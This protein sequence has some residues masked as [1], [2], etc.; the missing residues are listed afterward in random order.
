M[1]Q[2]LYIIDSHAAV[3]RAYHAQARLRQP[4]ASPDGHPT[5]A[6]F[7]FTN[8]LLALLRDHR[9]DLLAVA[10]D[11]PGPTFRHAMYDRYKA[12]RP[13]MPDDLRWQLPKVTA[14]CQGYSIPVFAVSG[15]EADDIIGTL[16]GQAAGAGLEVVIVSDD[17]DVLQLVGGPVRV[18]APSK[19]ERRGRLYDAAEVEKERGLPPA[20]LVDLLALTGDS[21][22]NIPG[23][24]G[25][26]PK[27]AVELLRRYGDLEA[28]LANASKEKGKRRENLEKHAEDARLSYRLATINRA[29]PVQLDPEAA[30]VSP[31]DVGRLLPIFQELGF[32]SLLKGLM[33]SSA[34]AQAREP[35]QTDY[36]AVTRPSELRALAHRLVEAELL[37]VDTETTGVDPM[38]AQLVGMS[39]SVREGEAWYVPV[40]APEGEPVCPMEE[41]LQLFKPL[42]ENPNLPKTGQNIKYDM[43]VLRRHGIDLRG[44]AF[45]SML[46]DYL[47]WPGKGLH[48]IDALALEHLSYRKVSTEEVIGRGREE[49]TMD[50]VPV[51]TVAP[52]ACEDAD[53]AL[54]LAGRLPPARWPK[55]PRAWS[56][57]WSSRRRK[58]TRPPG[59]SST[60]RAPSSWANCCSTSLSCRPAARPRPAGPPTRARCPN[61][62]R[63]TRCRAWCWSTGGWPSSRT[64]TSTSCRNGSIPQPAAS[65][66]R[67]TRPARRPGGSRR[68]SPTS[69]TSPSAPRWAARCAPASCPARAAGAWSRPTTRRSSCGCWPTSR[70]TRRWSRPSGTTRTFTASSPRR[71]SAWP[72]PT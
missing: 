25:I 58:S 17:K 2:R 43:I 7:G 53:I 49:T 61:W 30:R 45:D 46:A 33:A 70:A 22:D 20:R 50:K 4:L 56:A 44:V 65:T 14:V 12:H 63:S 16:A 15:F 35:G 54:R 9:P 28:V 1:S 37:S 38:R 69:R 39:F 29:V 6:V 72:R 11:S 24:P 51:A 47:L 41:V 31:P 21:S 42:L 34:P 19:D 52:Y 64:P 36:R 66:A 26:G 10:A 62:R 67:S 8:I 68:A 40:M 23:V 71:S 57:C 55:C 48:N 13:P 27:T 18:F 59:A 60:S 5:G 32:T 3:H